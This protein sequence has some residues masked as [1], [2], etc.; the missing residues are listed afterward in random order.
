MTSSTKSLSETSGDGFDYSLGKDPRDSAV[1]NTQDSGDSDADAVNSALQLSRQSVAGPPSKKRKLSDRDRLM[2]DMAS[3]AS[4]EQLIERIM[5]VTKK[6]MQ[7]VLA[8]SLSEIEDLVNVAVRSRRTARP[9]TYKL[10]G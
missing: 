5:H 7:H 2:L 3:D 4:N 6:K 10:G 8:Q 9:R 1:A